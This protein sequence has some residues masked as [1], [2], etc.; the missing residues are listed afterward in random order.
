MKKL[1]LLF[2]LSGLMLEMYGQSSCTGGMLLND[3][4]SATLTNWSQYGSPGTTVVLPA[5]NGC[6]STF[7]AMP[8]TNGGTAGIEQTVT[9]KLDTCYDLCY[10]YEFPPSGSLFNAKLLVAAITPGITPGMLLSGSFTASQ[11]QILDVITSPVAI[12]PTNTCIPA[13][14]ATGNFTSIVI[15]NKT[16]GN[17]GTDIR[18]DNVCL[19]RHACIT[20]PCD[21]LDANFSYAA[22]GNTVNFTDLSTFAVGSTLSWSWDFGDPPSGVN[23][24]SALQNPSH[25]YPGPGAYFACLYLSSVS[26]DGLT[27]C[28]DTFCVDVVIQGTVGIDEGNRGSLI[29]SPNPADDNIQ[30]K[31]TS[32]AEKIT[33]YNSFG[34]LIFQ[35]NVKNNSVE[36]PRSLTEGIYYAI[37]ETDT[38]TLHRKL[39]IKR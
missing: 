14:T 32:L 35:N 24:T 30:F 25:T 29:M 37:I 2:L 9:L 11:A 34:Q 7:A 18:V 1:I 38:G 28:Q 4:F 15:I 31:G 20:N 39:M 13:F 10:C 3:D 17:V 22:V 19:T 27:A 33:L 26:S 36:L 12:A 16:T 23:N 21:S 8:A 5:T 6:L